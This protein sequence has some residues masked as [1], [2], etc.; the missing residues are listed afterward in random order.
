MLFK[1]RQ[2]FTIAKIPDRNC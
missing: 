2:R 1:N